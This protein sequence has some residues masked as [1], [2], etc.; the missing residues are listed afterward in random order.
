MIDLSVF[1]IDAQTAVAI[2]LTVLLSEVI[3][4]E[5]DKFNF[6]FEK[7]LFKHWHILMPIILSSVSSLVIN[8]DYLTL[9][10]YI[11]SWAYIFAFS[12]VFYEIIV[13]RFKS[14]DRKSPEEAPTKECP[15]YATSPAQEPIITPSDTI[16][17]SDGGK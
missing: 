17:P 1:G 8:I 6:K 15:P 11:K 10:G 16:C 12:V 7:S 2:F 14:R 9:A 5:V 4:K 13:R 3:K